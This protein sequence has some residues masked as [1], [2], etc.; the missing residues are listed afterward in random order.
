MD[1]ATEHKLAKYS[2]PELVT[3]SKSRSCTSVSTR[4]WQREPVAFQ[5]VYQKRQKPDRGIWWLA[6]EQKQSLAEEEECL[7]EG[8][9]T[10]KDVPHT[11]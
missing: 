7:K 5:A 11:G 8:P 1:N 10:V 9:S 6:H 2:P 3:Q 4:Y